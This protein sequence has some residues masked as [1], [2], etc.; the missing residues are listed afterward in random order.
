MFQL[1]C[2]AKLVPS[3]DVVILLRGASLLGDTAEAQQ[4]L[5]PVLVLASRGMPPGTDSALR[6]RSERRTP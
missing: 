6:K 5:V 1:C 3:K 4:C 2:N